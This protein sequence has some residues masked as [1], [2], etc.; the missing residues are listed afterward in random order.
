MF[1]AVSE[2]EM[3][4]LKQLWQPEWGE[5]VLNFLRQNRGFLVCS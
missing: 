1:S 2:E 5:A 3:K 4:R